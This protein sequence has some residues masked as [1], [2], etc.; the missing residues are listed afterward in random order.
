MFAEDA[1]L[2]AKVVSARQATLADAARDARADDDAIAELGAPRSG[3]HSVDLPH[4]VAAQTVRIGE[5]EVRHSAPNPDV[6]VVQSDRADAHARFTG[7]GL[8][9]IDGLAGENLGA[10]MSAKNDGFG[11]HGRYAMSSRFERDA[12]STGRTA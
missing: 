2:A 1:V 11:L 7:T 10:T 8:R 4:D 9:Q 12:P 5:L 3:P 6:E